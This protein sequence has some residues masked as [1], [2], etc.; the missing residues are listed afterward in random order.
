MKVIV[1]LL[2][3]TAVY[4][5]RTLQAEY[6]TTDTIYWIRVI[7]PTSAEW[8]TKKDTLTGEE[9]L[10]WIDY[11]IEL[12]KKDTARWMWLWRRD[13]AFIGQLQRERIKITGK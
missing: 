9:K 5:Q 4:G 7:E 3:T 13:T 12:A 2:L 6:R 10:I 8:S 1:F 11:W